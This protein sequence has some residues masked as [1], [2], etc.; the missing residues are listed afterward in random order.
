MPKYDQILRPLKIKKKLMKTRIMSTDIQPF[1]IQGPEP[2]PTENVIQYY[3]GIAANGAGIVTCRCGGMRN[4]IPRMERAY[5]PARGH[6]DYDIYDQAVQNYFSQMA[7]AI[8]FHDSLASISLE[9]AIP[10]ELLIG[11]VT[12][13]VLE[14]LGEYSSALKGDKVVTREE[15]KE[16]ISGVAEQAQIY[17]EL[18]FDCCELHMSYCGF[19]TSLAM[20]PV[21]NTR[22]DEYG[23]S[24]ENRFRMAMEMLQAIRDAC[25]PDFI[26]IVHI[27]G[28]EPEE[29]GYKLHDVIRFAKMAEGLIDI[30][31]IRM[32][33]NISAHPTGFNSTK[34]HPVT[35]DMA[36]EVK[37]QG[38][39]MLVAA[40]GG[41]QD[42]DIIEAAL[43]SGKIDLVA[44]ART[45]FS[46]WD[47]YYKCL[48]EGRGEDVIPCIR[49]LKCTG[50]SL[51]HTKIN[52]CSV[53]PKMGIP[54][55]RRAVMIKA[56][57][58]VKRVAVIGG[59]PA[60]MQ[61]AINLR[62]RGH[63]VTIFEKTD[64][65]G[66]QL[67]HADYAEFKW[68]IREFKD[69]LIRQVSKGGIEIRLNADIRPEQIREEEFDVV[70]AAL[71]A[72]PQRPAIPG[73]ERK[74]VWVPIDVF[75]KTEQLGKRVVV[76]GGGETGTETG[77]YLA[78]TGHEVIVVSR[79]EVLAKE[80]LAFFHYGETLKKVCRD[81]EHFG[82]IT[83]A[84]TIKIAEGFLVYVDKAGEEK[85]LEFD[86]VVVAGGSKALTEEALAFYGRTN[87]FYL[88]GDAKAPGSI[89]TSTK[90][91]YAAASRI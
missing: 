43:E 12:P 17:K 6:S 28:E 20:S 45:F 4:R 90:T 18:G 78:K 48:Q 58:K 14:Q 80:S 15:I 51:P 36:A 26:I 53:N 62:E 9:L 89:L 65:L 68:P 86:D 56:P 21:I 85:T 49:C 2:Y 11:E 38:V 77:L 84:T 54:A 76:V 81:T 70:V 63:K 60:G 87:E 27:S 74:D 5:L 88:I 61:A 13:E 67:K 82:W 41:F 64:S 34:E 91:A 32:G 59:G 19:I 40:V 25:G 8:H 23:G 37:A 39:H 22:K 35:L 69:Y 73:A 47:N 16:I 72:V 10:M 3:A 30:L 83:Q 33:D 66:G 7:D 1:L 31:Q 44:M 46:N 79:Q 24:F 57:E 42:P 55:A 71:G 75:G 29:N 52:L 50:D